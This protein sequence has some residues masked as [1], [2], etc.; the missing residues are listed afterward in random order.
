[1]ETIDALLE[2]HGLRGIMPEERPREVRDRAVDESAL[3]KLFWD[4]GS[5]DPFL[6]N[7][8]V[9]FVVGALAR[10]QHALAM[11]QRGQRAT[12]YAG[13]LAVHMSYNTRS[14]KWQIMLDRTIP[15]N[16]KKRALAEEARL[17]RRRVA[18][19]SEAEQ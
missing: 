8:Y 14:H 13:G 15:A 6:T 2:L 7:L 3:K 1:M 18:G 5:E 9:G 10:N 19:V 17:V 11:T 16:V 4:Y 12:V